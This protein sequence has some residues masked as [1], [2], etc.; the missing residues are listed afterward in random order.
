MRFL[1]RARA[2]PAA[3]LPVVKP[4]SV[5]SKLRRQLCWVDSFRTHSD[6]LYLESISLS[7]F[8]SIFIYFFQNLLPR[9]FIYSLLFRSLSLSL[10]LLSPFISGRKGG[11]LGLKLVAKL[12]HHGGD[13]TRDAVVPGSR[14]KKSERSRFN[15]S[16]GSK[17]SKAGAAWGWPCFTGFHSLWILKNDRIMIHDQV[18]GKLFVIDQYYHDWRWSI[19]DD[20]PAASLTILTLSRWKLGSR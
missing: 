16:L 19:N 6:H 5:S 7:H 14:E 8:D 12:G 1:P 13:A 3:R 9:R 18:E 11:A 20:P 2:T 15:L 17:M 4:S 10:S